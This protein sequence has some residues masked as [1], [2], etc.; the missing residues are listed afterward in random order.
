VKK[1]PKPAPKSKPRWAVRNEEQIYEWVLW[2]RADQIRT[3]MLK[4]WGLTAVEMPARVAINA[5]TGRL[6]K[7][8]PTGL[9]IYST[10]A[11]NDEGLRGDV[12]GRHEAAHRDDQTN[13]Q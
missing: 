6:E 11:A 10:E 3:K 9:D 4:R 2:E 5:K 13:R 8:Q 1:K 7:K 12:A